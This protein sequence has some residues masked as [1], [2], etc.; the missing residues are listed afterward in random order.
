MYISVKRTISMLMIFVMTVMT[1]AAL[2]VTG[3]KAWAAE[4]SGLYEG[5][6]ATFGYGS[7]FKTSDGD[8]Y[9]FTG[10]DQN[11]MQIYCYNYQK[12]ESYT[13]G[14]RELTGPLKRYRIRTSQDSFVGYCIEHG[15]M[16]NS[17]LQ[18]E[19]SSNRNSVITRGLG[20]ATMQNIKLC[21]FYGRQNGDSIYNLLDSPENGGLGFRDSEFFQKNSQKY[22]L[23]DWEI[24]TAMLIRESQQKFRDSRFRLKSEGN[25]LYYTDSWRGTP[26]E[27]IN[28]DH[29]INPL[30]GKAAY[31]IYKY[32][33]KER[34]I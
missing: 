1:A 21:L 5:Q 32:M 34:R 20:E 31:D 10:A 27:L 33:E 18:L 25:G 6:A 30:R 28:K 8:T 9:Q 11:W 16:V 4:K 26:T 29:Y 23:D 14:A 22:T 15:V 3:E 17:S 12:D 19:S 2:P 13:G 7:A 24:A